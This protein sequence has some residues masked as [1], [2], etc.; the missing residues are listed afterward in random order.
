MRLVSRELAMTLIKMTSQLAQLRC[1][2]RAFKSVASEMRV[3][4]RCVRIGEAEVLEVAL[5]STR[6][7]EHDVGFRESVAAAGEQDARRVRDA[8]VVK[9]RRPLLAARVAHLPTV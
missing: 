1:C 5:R 9:L 4:V 2:L 6:G 8:R 7:G 3:P